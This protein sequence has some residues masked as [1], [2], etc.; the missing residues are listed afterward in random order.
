MT[1]K[2]NLGIQIYF[3]KNNIFSNWQKNYIPKISLKPSIQILN[4]AK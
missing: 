4:T 1:K 2:Q 3:Y